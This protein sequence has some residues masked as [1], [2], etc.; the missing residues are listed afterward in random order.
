MGRG[1][2]AAFPAFADAFD[3]ACAALDP[4]LERPL[5]E[6]VWAGAGSVEAALLDR[7]EW[8]Q[9]ALFAVEVALFRLVESWGVVPRAVGG[10][11]IGEFAAAYAAGVFSLEDAA[12]LVTARGRLMAA[13]PEAGA[14]LS[15]RAPEA[16]VLPHLAAWAGRVSVAAVNGPRSVVVAGSG[17]AVDAVEAA[18]TGA[19]HRT[20]RLRVS[21]AFHSPLMEPMLAEFR[22]VAESVTY[23]E[24]VLELLPGAGTEL[25][26]ATGGLA[27]PEY[28]V[29]QV[30]EAVRFADLTARLAADGTTCLL[31]LG[32]D[33]ILTAMAE[34]CFADADAHADAGT[35]PD[36]DGASDSDADPAARPVLVPV[37]R[38]DRDE[39]A[40]AVRAAA[41]LHCAG[42][43]P[44][45]P[46][47]LGTGGRPADAAGL[48]T[49]PFQRQRY[50]LDSPA[51]ATDPEDAAFWTAVEDGDLDGLGAR[52]GLADGQRD[53]L[54]TVLEPLG[55]WRRER[56]AR[57]R[58]GALRHRAG[59]RRLTEPAVP[60]LSGTWLLVTPKVDEADA[61]VHASGLTAT[62]AADHAA[63]LAAGPAA[64][65]ASDRTAGPAADGAASFAAGHATGLAGTAGRAA[66]LTAAQAATLA[67][68]LDAVEA[69]LAAHGARTLR[70]LVDLDAGAPDRA[71]FAALLT[72]ALDGAA[73][74]GVLSLLA[75]HGADDDP[76]APALAGTV[77]LLQALGDL[78]HAAPLWSATRDAVGGV[79]EGDG[80]AAPAGAALW[81]LGR[82]AALEHPDRWGGLVDLPSGALDAAAGARLCGVL[83]DP[84][85]ED[86]VAVRADGTYGRR[87]RRVA[88]RPTG[89]ARWT[90]GG[91]T[92]LVTGGTGALGGHVA[93]WLAGRGAGHLLLVGR[94][95]PDAPGAAELRAELT[96]AGTEVTVAACDTADRASVARLLAEIPGDRPLTA[97]VHAAG[98]L[99]DGVLDALTPDRLAAVLRAKAES[100]RVLDELT[101]DL[102]LSAF[103]LFSSF[104]GTLGNPGQAN[105]AAANAYLD[106]LAERRAAD[107][108][109]AAS[110]AWGPWAAEG[111]AADREVV[112][113][114]RRGGVTPL[115]PETALRALAA[116]LDEGAAHPVTG[117]EAA[118]AVADVE[119]ARFAPAF[120][121]ARPAPLLA[122]LAGSADPGAADGPAG[123]AGRE[124]G[125]ATELLGR[126]AGVTPAERDRLL[127]EL[128]RRLTAEVLGHSGPER[129]EPG[130]G[131]LELGFDSL[132][133]VELRNRL[134]GATGLRLP[135][136]LLFDQPTPVALARHLAGELAPEQPSA[137]AGLLAGLDA[138]ETALAAGE[139]GGG[140]L[141]DAARRRVTARLETLLSKWREA[142]AGPAGGDTEAAPGDDL[143]SASVDEVLSLIDAEFGL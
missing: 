19:G 119:W 80:P 75:L 59:W 68:D 74:T 99:E 112:E 132:T 17:E 41:A 57:A 97:V 10:H 140:E 114:A 53:A 36:A 95:G 136:T 135:S 79:S 111:M 103:V 29:R 32:P 14:M 96:A 73:P 69:A 35:G 11:S 9:P 78:G 93:R 110:V 56:G 118:V 101:R 130:R 23:R 143:E 46:A 30:R 100:A 65:P 45:H 108:R 26:A 63:R 102:D 142:Q 15:V 55:A 92:V 8:T 107:G 2:H 113:R 16:E 72:A 98:V 20:R 47:P 12:R 4:Y 21:H 120:T 18:L 27:G 88:A 22:A 3:A 137:E 126:L 44:R 134:G 139:S 60:V 127:L 25:A 84:A 1:L 43:G 104:S 82:V 106:G 33:A 141:D 77:A 115:E 86:Q 49:Y 123:D 5:K 105:Y 6:V 133:A 28:W 124:R 42:A 62:H 128:V 37:L 71:A 34:D 131:F 51:P 76:Y 66:H 121:A 90:A 91:G 70:L 7:T 24:P 31:E 58:A 83:S 129:I 125:G 48:P 117:A 39:A 116:I 81:G 61:A 87:L 109:A 40:T 52:L 50:W 122:E 94:R 138:L 54:G 89:G 67:A 64:E 38:R 85:G 13:L